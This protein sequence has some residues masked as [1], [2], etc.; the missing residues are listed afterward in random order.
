[1]REGDSTATFITGRIGGWCARRRWLVAP[2]GLVALILAIVA[3]AAVGADTDPG[4]GGTGE[5]IR[6]T[7]LLEERFGD[8]AASDPPTELLVFSHPR[9]TVDDPEYRT[10]VTGLVE[11]LRALRFEVVR[12]SPVP[13]R[14][15]TR[16]VGNT[17][18]HYDTGAPRA[19]S[20]LVATREG[21]GDVTYAVI[22]LE[23]EADASVASSVPFVFEEIGLVTD[24][25]AA[26]SQ[27]AEGFEIVI[28][29]DASAS[30][31]SEDN[32]AEDFSQASTINLPLTFIILI[33]ALGT[34]LAALL[35]IGLA[36]GGVIT[37]I[38]VMVLVSRLYPL[39]PVFIQVVLLIGLAA[40]IDYALFMIARYRR[41]RE[42]GAERPAAVTRAWSTTG[43][44]VLIAAT[45]TV[46]SI[47]GM[48]LVGDPV[49][50]ALGMAA[51]VAVIVAA[52]IAMT[53]LP[54]LTGD[55]LNR[56]R[57]PGTRRPGDDRPSLVTR[58][59]MPVVAAAIRRPGIA[60]GAAVIA[61]LVLAS[62]LLGLSTGFNG[63]RGLNDD[64]EAKAAFLALE[65]NFTLGLAAPAQVVVDAGVNENVFDPQVQAA[66][67][68]LVESVA[69]EN[70]AAQ[71]EGRHVPFGPGVER[72][73][74]NAG[75][76]EVVA[77]PINADTGEQKA[78]D[79]V[80]LLRNQL[81]P[82]AFADVPAQVLVTGQAAG[83]SDF[84][85]NINARTPFV[86]AFV[87][88]TAFLLLL[89]MYRSPLIAGI[90]VVLN[91]LAVAAA[92]G[93]LVLVFQE[94]YAFE[95]LFDFEAT[96]I[97]ESWLPLFVF[98]IMFG[99][100][101]DYLTFAIGRV[102]ELHDE[103]L[104]TEAA[105]RQ[106]V[107]DGFGVIFSAA[108]VMA[109]VALVFAFTRDIGLQQF[110]FT[111]AV[112]VVL[113]ATIILAVLLPAALRLAGDRLWYLPYWLEWLPGGRPAAGP[114]PEAVER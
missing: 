69:A 38:G 88:I 18:T 55:W 112:A 70:A 100:S 60:G 66:V 29:G 32:I 8:L 78:F 58:I 15:S 12:E 26:A 105:I 30:K 106:S 76:T 56:L 42:D 34:L 37:A 107:T 41:E 57:V 83:Q 53:V 45:T 68:R 24:T 89:V 46:L 28:G 73:I 17:T 91:L 111:L 103:G 4:Q 85:E 72:A 65:E 48:Y 101:M 5:S 59:A 52:I 82:E 81:I 87:L 23:G 27:R 33:I 61:L 51:M 77:I 94:G 19:L 47:G 44:N 1:M 35:P 31:Q 64:V 104:A 21:A 96:G 14:V 90:T 71:T 10:T 54:A 2:L 16:I 39:E 43:R 95:G 97:I 63:A 114:A 50:T 99:I 113:D 108:A 9:L 11:E 92:Y 40:G 25:V 6:A 74:N 22:E 102:K 93:L 13:G 98:T 84:T 36:F 3:I 75:D 109:T 7:E 20:P 49:F 62:P 110:G 86:Y 80:A 79:A 67:T